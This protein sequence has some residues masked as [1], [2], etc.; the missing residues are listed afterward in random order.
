MRSPTAALLWEIWRRNSQ[1]MWMLVGVTI[2]SWL[3]DFTARGGRS[4]PSAGGPGPLN[5]LLAMFSFLLLFGIFSYTESS[6][7]TG[8]GRFPHRLFTLPVSSLLLVAVPV[9]A[10]IVAVELLYL[11]WMGRLTSMFDDCQFTSDGAS[12]VLPG[13][14]SETAAWYPAHSDSGPRQGG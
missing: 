10:G 2:V 1:A 12:V 9:V 13:T 6:G 4:P 5:E 14:F 11:A 7:D 3:A 8:I